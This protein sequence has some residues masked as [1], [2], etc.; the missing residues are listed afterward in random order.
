MDL[1]GFQLAVGNNSLE[2]NMGNTIFRIMYAENNPLVQV[3]S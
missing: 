3:K 2:I 1:Q